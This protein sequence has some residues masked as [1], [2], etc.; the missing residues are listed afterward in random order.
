MNTQNVTDY[1]DQ[2]YREPMTTHLHDSE[3]LQLATVDE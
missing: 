1:V 3:A 2:V